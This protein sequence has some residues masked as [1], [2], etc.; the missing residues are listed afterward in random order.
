M[1]LLPC[2]LPVV[3]WCLCSSE[4]T[5]VRHFFFNLDSNDS[6]T[7][8]SGMKDKGVRRICFGDVAVTTENQKQRYTEPYRTMKRR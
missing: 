6:E 1:S 3:L 7:E 5:D 8:G 2:A 4:N